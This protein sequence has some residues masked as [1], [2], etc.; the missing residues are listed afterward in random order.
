MSLSKKSIDIVKK[1]AIPV[2]QNAQEITKLMYEIL[3]NDYPEVLPIF[4]NTDLDQHKKL[5][6]AVASY[7]ANIENLEV[8]DNTIEKIVSAHI[9]MKVKAHHYPMV[10]DSILKAIQEVLGDGA[11][12]DVIEGWREAYF[13]LA[14]ILMAKEK[15]MCLN[16]KQ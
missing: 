4:E 16:K 7:A 13:Y 5:A 8:L 12:P 3:F 6:V 11:T 15:E 14:D 2:A 10:G 1:T 9:K